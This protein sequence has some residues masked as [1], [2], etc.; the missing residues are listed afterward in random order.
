LMNIT[1]AVIG[2]KQEHKLKSRLMMEDIDDDFQTGL[3]L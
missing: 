3:S 2:R 1:F